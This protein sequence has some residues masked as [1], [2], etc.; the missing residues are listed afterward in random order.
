[1]EDSESG[2]A[3]QQQRIRDDVVLRYQVYCKQSVLHCSV[4]MFCLR[5][6]SKGRQQGLFT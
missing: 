3:P 1:M 2:V 5:P 4:V 6:V